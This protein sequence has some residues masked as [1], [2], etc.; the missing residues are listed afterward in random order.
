MDC[1]SSE[2]NRYLRIGNRTFYED[3]DQ[4]VEPSALVVVAVDAC[5]R[6]LARNTLAGTTPTIFCTP[7]GQCTP[8]VEFRPSMDLVSDPM[9]HPSVDRPENM[10]LWLRENPDMAAIYGR[11]A[12]RLFLAACQFPAMHTSWLKEM[13]G[14]SPGEVSRHLRRFLDTGLVAVFDG[15]HCLSQ[16]GMKGAA[17]MSLALPSVIRCRHGA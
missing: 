8:A 5:A 13:V 16:L 15:R 3:P 17:N 9:G 2:E 4:E 6:E 12:H 1:Y 14:G 10:G 11:Q 7:D